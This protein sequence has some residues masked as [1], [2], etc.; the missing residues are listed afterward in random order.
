MLL[1]TLY[2]HCW[3]LFILWH[4]HI[5]LFYNFSYNFSLW[6]VVVAA[7]GL[8]LCCVP[9]QPVSCLCLSVCHRY[10][11]V[12]QCTVARLFCAIQILLL[13]HLPSVPWSVPASELYV[14]LSVTGIVVS[15]EHAMGRPSQWAVLSSWS[16][17]TM[18]VYDWSQHRSWSW[19]CRLLWTTSWRLVCAL[20]LSS[21]ATLSLH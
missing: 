5:A 17:F 4:S 3:R 13:T 9:C 20:L 19:R 18:C 16:S 14:C 8:P 6:G 7:S 11:P 10:C 2:C 21:Y 1:W 15:A 12:C